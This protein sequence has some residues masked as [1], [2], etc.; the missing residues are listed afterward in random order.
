MDLLTQAYNSLLNIDRMNKEFEA[1]KKA[2]EDKH[3]KINNTQVKTTSMKNQ[4][5]NL[6]WS[7]MVRFNIST[8]SFPQ[9]DNYTHII[10]RTVKNVF[11][12]DGNL[13]G[14]VKMGGQ[15]LVVSKDANYSEDSWDIEELA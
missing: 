3:G 15:S 6:T 4:D 5:I 8:S 11:K 10:K 14:V 9:V 7:E 13:Y 12:K 1:N 2:F